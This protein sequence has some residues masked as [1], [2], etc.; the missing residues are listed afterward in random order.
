MRLTS[1]LLA[2][3][4][5]GGLY[6]WFALRGPAEDSV[7]AAV[8]EAPAEAPAEAAAEP[9][10]EV[11]VVESHAEPVVN[12]LTLRGRTLPN[13]RV[14]VTAE[15]EGLVVS[16]PPRK[17]E[18]VAKGDLLCRIDPGARLAALKEAR[19]KLA[20]AR[21]EAE[22]AEQLADRGFGPET[23]RLAR[24]A[25]LEAAQARVEQIELDIARLEIRAP[26]A[27][28]LE[29]DAAETG[30]RLGIGDVCASIV[31]LSPLKVLGYASELE[32]DRIAVGQPATARLVNGETADGRISHIAPVADSDTRTFAVEVALPN[33]EHR[34]RAGMTAEIR[35][36]LPAVE[37]H[38]VPQSA[39][40]LDDQGRLGVRVAEDGRA[41]FF[42]VEIVREGAEAVW[43]AGLPGT[44]RVMVAGQEFVTDGRAVRAVPLAE[45]ALR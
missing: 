17:G 23:T 12:S 15:T 33:P 19:A 7:T 45:S 27:G 40:T 10:V 29:E 11:V 6:W 20:E 25:A 30:A 39:L 13:R 5:A 42:P 18:T 31:D 38:R 8:A 21:I 3:L 43:L 44:A 4:L 26:F 9:P 36:D 35:I 14:E 22:A 2:L 28:T 34:L 37:A 24:R 1:L 41:R 32:V 16:E